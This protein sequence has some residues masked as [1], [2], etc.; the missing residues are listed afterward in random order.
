MN[1]V[2]YAVAATVLALALPAYAGDVVTGTVNRVVDGDTLH[3]VVD[4][5]EIKV[6]LAGIDAPERK[7]PYGAKSTAALSSLT[8]GKTC[9]IEIEDTDRYGRKVSF[10]TCDSNVS[11]NLAMVSQGNAWVYRQYAHN[12]TGAYACLCF[13][14]SHAKYQQLGL[15]TLPIEDRVP[16][17]EWRKKL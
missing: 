15:W 9:S 8:L 16:P 11:A 3:A 5:K 2:K 14:E 6:R 12:C 7:Q 13:G 10:V 4:G 1:I 17:W